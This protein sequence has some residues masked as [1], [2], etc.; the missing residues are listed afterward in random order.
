MACGILVPWPRIEPMPPA[1]EGGFLAPGPLGK[2][3]QQVCCCSSR[4]VM[5][6]SLWPHCSTPG[7][8]VLHH[9]LELAQTYVHWVSDAIQP[10]HPLSSPSP[11]ALTLSQH[12]VLFQWGSSWHQVT[13]IGASASASVLPMNIQLESRDC[14]NPLS[15]SNTEMLA[16]SSVLN[17]VSE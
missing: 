13:S 12:Q 2:F 14:L 7:F 9:L 6:D 8:P 15:I 16:A 11:P 17:A 5:S 3:L 10:S 1:L 4:S